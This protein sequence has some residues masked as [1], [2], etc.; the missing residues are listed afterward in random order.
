M[1]RTLANAAVANKHS[2]FVDVRN[3]YSNRMQFYQCL[4][5]ST[6]MNNAAAD[7]NLVGRTGRMDSQKLEAM[8][9]SFLKAA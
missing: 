5:I 2:E 3:G 7:H 8:I 1:P 4:F 9:D 6:A